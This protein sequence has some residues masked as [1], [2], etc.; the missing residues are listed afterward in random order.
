[1]GASLLYVP[2]AMTIFGGIFL[3]LWPLFLKPSPQANRVFQLVNSARTTIRKPGLRQSILQQITSIATELRTS[4]GV[5]VNVKSAERLH[6]AGL[7][8]PADA[9]MFFAAQ[10]LMPLVGAFGG[11]FIPSNTLYW[12]VMLGFAGFAVPHLWLTSMMRRRNDR[13]RYSLP[14]VIDL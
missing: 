5:S 14:D 2:F 1:M 8:S 10:F 9:D 12:V 7:R 13:I 3:L 4:L 11:S 6:Q